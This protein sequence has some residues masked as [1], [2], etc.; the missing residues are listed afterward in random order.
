[1]N[2]IKW[3]KVGRNIKIGKLK[4]EIKKEDIIVKDPSGNIKLHIIVQNLRKIFPDNL[5]LLLSNE[6]ILEK[7]D[8]RKM[9]RAGWIRK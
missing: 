7:L 1:M 4:A 3:L 5:I 2:L 9:N 8:E 6:V